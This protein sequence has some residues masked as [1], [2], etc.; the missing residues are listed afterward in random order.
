MEQ[1]AFEFQV[2]AV[3]IS[4]TSKRSAH[5]H[6]TTGISMQTLRIKPFFILLKVPLAPIEAKKVCGPKR[7]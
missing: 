4:G 3:D 2:S 6:R 7:N 5:P 1:S